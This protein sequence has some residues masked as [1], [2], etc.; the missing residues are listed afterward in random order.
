MRGQLRIL[1]QVRACTPVAAGRAVLPAVSH[2]GEGYSITMGSATDVR[3]F[4]TPWL[5]M[6]TMKSVS[7]K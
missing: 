2:S 6:D 3:V 4:V 1:L 7:W 5:A